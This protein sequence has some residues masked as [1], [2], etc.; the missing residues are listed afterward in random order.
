M[1]HIGNVHMDA[2][3]AVIMLFGHVIRI[4]SYREREDPGERTQQANGLPQHV[5]TATR[6]LA[7]VCT[8]QGKAGAEV[9][10]IG[11]RTLRI[12]STEPVAST[13]A[14][15]LSNSTT[16]TPASVNRGKE[17]LR[18]LSSHSLDRRVAPCAKACH[19]SEPQ[20]HIPCGK[21][22][23]PTQKIFSSASVGWP[24][25]SHGHECGEGDEG[26]RSPHPQGHSWSPRGIH[27]RGSSQSR[28]SGLPC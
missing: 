24:H 18:V 17:L 1:Q 4:G 26:R 23:L 19:H 11:G 13:D 2:F 22:R 6:E 5:R 3:H 7:R 16:G 28:N 10:A 9:H 21:P 15:T 14:F 20:A 12:T 25:Q 8:R 27:G